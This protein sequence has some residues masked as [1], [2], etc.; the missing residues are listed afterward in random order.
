MYLIR[1]ELGIPQTTDVTTNDMISPFDACGVILI[2]YTGVSSSCGKPMF[3]IKLRIYMI[4]T[5]ISDAE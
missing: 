4:S 1:Y 2:L 3:R 5:A